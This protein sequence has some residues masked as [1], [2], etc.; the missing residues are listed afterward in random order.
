MKHSEIT[1]VETLPP[2][3]LLANIIRALARVDSMT[4]FQPLVNAIEQ[5]PI[6]AAQL[7]A[8]ANRPFYSTGIPIHTVSG[9]ITTIGLR[10]T[11]LLLFRIILKEK[12][13]TTC[14][15]FSMTHFLYDTIMMACLSPVLARKFSLDE[16]VI[17]KLHILGLLQSIGILLLVYQFP[18]EMESVLENDSI[19]NEIKDKFGMDYHE[20]GAR[21]LNHWGLPNSITHPISLLTIRPNVLVET[22]LLRDSKKLI[23][24]HSYSHVDEFQSEPHFDN[25]DLLFEKFNHIH[26]EV[27]EFIKVF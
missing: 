20:I 11:K 14:K 2:F 22:R 26:D 4:S 6:I 16:S 17:E 5:E 15:S 24:L 19:N 8:A 25:E 7:V 18:N 3:R 23:E 12:F 10:A 1:W 13:P 9:S 21:L 27:V